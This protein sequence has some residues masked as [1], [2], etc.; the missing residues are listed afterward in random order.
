MELTDTVLNDIKQKIIKKI[1][2]PYLEK[3][4]DRIIFNDE[5]LRVLLAIVQDQNLSKDQEENYIKSVMLIQI[6]L[7]TH[8]LVKNDDEYM[9]PRKRQLTVLAGDYYSGLYYKTLADEAN[10]RLIDKLATGVKIANENKIAV[11]K[12]EVKTVNQFVESMKLIHTSIYQKLAHFFGDYTWEALAVNWIHY[13]D[14]IQNKEFYIDYIVKNQMKIGKDDLKL[15]GS[16]N[17]NSLQWLDQYIEHV[18]NHIENILID[19]PDYS[20][21]FKKHLIKG[22][23]PLVIGQSFQ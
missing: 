13:H 21:Q 11:Y 7:D 22:S 12:K 6:A 2:H 18:R 14:L 1:T 5:K 20:L 19:F 4:L 8:D 17:S 9:E 10:I 15:A 3:E 16:N 23:D